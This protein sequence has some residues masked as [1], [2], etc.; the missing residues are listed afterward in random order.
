[1][2]L[3]LLLHWFDANVAPG[4]YL[5]ATLPIWVLDYCL[6]AHT[7]SYLCARENERMQWLQIA[8]GWNE[9]K[10]ETQV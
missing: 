10:I 9:W 6:K 3:L 2:M 1:M 4:D 7:G 5:F 8:V